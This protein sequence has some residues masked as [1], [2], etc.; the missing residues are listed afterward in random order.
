MLQA[1]LFGDWKKF[2]L[3]KSI[4]ETYV[5]CTERET[6]KLLMEQKMILHIQGVTSYTIFISGAPMRFLLYTRLDVICRESYVFFYFLVTSR[7]W[8]SVAAFH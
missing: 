5:G 8:V 6:G 3:K 2:K 1:I 7:I 4:E